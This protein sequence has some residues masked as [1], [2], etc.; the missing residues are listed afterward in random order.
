MLE[1]RFVRRNQVFALVGVSPY[2]ALTDLEDIDAVA[3]CIC[4]LVHSQAADELERDG[5]A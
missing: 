5:V 4:D 3:A 1:F 2:P